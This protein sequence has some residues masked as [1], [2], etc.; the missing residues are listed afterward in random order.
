MFQR[1]LKIL[2][3]RLEFSA[4]LPVILLARASR[5]QLGNDAV[6]MRELVTRI[7]DL[8]KADIKSLSKR[9][10]VRVELQYACLAGPFRHPLQHDSG[11]L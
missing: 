4:L 1:R 9:Y 7:R 11:R 2:L 5:F 3:P 6:E 10:S 8:S